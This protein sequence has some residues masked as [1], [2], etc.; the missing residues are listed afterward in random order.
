MGAPH[1]NRNAAGK[2]KMSVSPGAKQF[3]G[4]SWSKNIISRTKNVMGKRPELL[5][6]LQSKAGTIPQNT[7]RIKYLKVPSRKKLTK[8]YGSFARHYRTIY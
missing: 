3:L 6:R 5:R 8:M 2:H 4:S 7:A 1:G